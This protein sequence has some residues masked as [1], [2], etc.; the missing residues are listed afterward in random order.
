MVERV[1]YRTRCH[2]VREQVSLS[3]VAAPLLQLVRGGGEWKACCPFHV[4]RTPSFTIYA[5]D[6]RFKC[7]GCGAQGDVL[8]FLMRLHRTT[9]SSALEML[10]GDASRMSG[11]VA[12]GTCTRQYAGG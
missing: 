9:L 12:A 1:S 4:D 11:R 2:E 7:F 10:E 8:D 5:G 3:E 6:R